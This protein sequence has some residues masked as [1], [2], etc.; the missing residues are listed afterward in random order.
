M[1][2]PTVKRRPM[3]D[4][5]EFEK[6]LRKPLSLGQEDDDPLA[7]LARFGG[8]QVDPYLEDP[9]RSVFEPQTRQAA[10]ALRAGQ[11]HG[12]VKERAS[13]EPLIRGDFSAIEAG[14]LGADL[15]E[16]A[17]SSAPT[18]VLDHRDEMDRADHL[19][20][21]EVEDANE[22]STSYE[23]IRSRRPLYVMAA[24]IIAGVAGIFASFAFKGAVSTQDDVATIKAIDGPV[25]VQPETSPGSDNPSED[26]TILGGLPQQNPVAAVTNNDQPSD[27]TAQTGAAEGEVS[28]QNAVAASAGAAAVPVPAPPAQAQP[29]SSAGPQSI[30]ELIEPKKVRTVAVRPDGT[31][32]PSDAPPAAT[33]AGQAPA[34]RPPS[35]PVPKPVAKAANPKTA[36]RVAAMP[37]P[38]G[39]SVRSTPQPAQTTVAPQVRTA[40][41]APRTFAVQL[42]APFTEQEAREQQARLMQKYGSDLAGY[43]PSIQKAQVSGKPRY[44]VRFSGLTSRDQATAL[45]EKV[46]SSGGNCFVAKN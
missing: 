34:V 23:T 17:M 9:Y 14:L 1:S 42:A 28:S 19:P 22:A 26:P 46:K 16:D 35:P 21:P 45:C 30:A 37:K 43:Q 7:E 36:A 27:L 24:M 13:Q 39:G 33:Q 31:R 6:R 29:R 38:A 11:I 40:E 8:G 20:Y 12:E 3:I 5:E 44:R 15:P 10:G 25:K 41:A 18:M 4:F 32:L 2:E